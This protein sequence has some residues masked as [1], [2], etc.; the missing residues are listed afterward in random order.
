LKSRRRTWD[1]E[2]A[3]KRERWTVAIAGDSASC[4]GGVTCSAGAIRAALGR[5]V[6][7]VALEPVSV[8][9]KPQL[10][11]AF[12]DV[13]AMPRA[14]LDNDVY[15][16]RLRELN[17]CLGID[18]II[19]NAE[20]EV[21]VLQCLTKE[22][23]ELDVG[24][25]L[26][27]RLALERTVS[28][29]LRPLAKELGLRSPETFAVTDLGSASRAIK[30]LGLPVVVRSNGRIVELAHSSRTAEH[31]VGRLL[32]EGATQLALQEF[33]RGEYFEVAIVRDVTSAKKLSLTMHK[34][35]VTRF[36][37]LWAGTCTEEPEVRRFAERV[38]DA[39]HWH[40][41]CSVEVF[42]DWQGKLL[43]ASLRPVLPT[44]SHAC[45]A[46]GPNLQLALA[47]LAMGRRL[48]GPVNNASRLYY[49]GEPLELAAEL[50]KAPLFATMPVPADT[51]SSA[52]W[53]SPRVTSNAS[54]F[55]NL[56]NNT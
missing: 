19:A 55:V 46:V 12:D 31:V 6:R 5:R 47:Y 2:V 17:E 45:A 25:A 43:L 52:S 22:L 20:P 51:A 10:D 18:V 8:R 29:Q 21:R 42:K 26:P 41:S 3:V 13:V 23:R 30:R 9:R 49:V 27:S 32:S 15:A 44:W 4:D 36:G 40:G 28:G 24:T 53:W 56:E 54:T 1:I 11:S 33:I 35:L 48:R 14:D 50:G 16:A 37:R 39:L 34:S 38:T 7:L